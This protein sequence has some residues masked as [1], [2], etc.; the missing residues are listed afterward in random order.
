VPHVARPRRIAPR[1]SAALGLVLAAACSAGAGVARAGDGEPQAVASA[2]LDVPPDLVW[3]LLADL[4]AWPERAPELT[5]IEMGH[6][7]DGSRRVRQTT[8]VLGLS[9]FHASTVSVDA[10]RRRIE[11]ALDPAEPGDFERVDSAWTVTPGPS[12]G[13]LV[14]LRSH[15]RLRS[16]LPAFLQRRALQDTVDAMMRSLVAAAERHAGLPPVGAR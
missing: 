11:L 12:R 9:F 3:G 14:E 7:P 6:A 13:T 15:A 16:P 5:T 4:D 8:R 1:A 10:A 2:R